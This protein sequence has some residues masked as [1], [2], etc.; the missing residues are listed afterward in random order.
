LREVDR[1]TIDDT[2]A[3]R[4]QVRNLASALDACS[5]GRFAAVELTLQTAPPSPLTRGDWDPAIPDSL[6]ELMSRAA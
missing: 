5:N 6:A 2:P 4:D 1:G 3:L